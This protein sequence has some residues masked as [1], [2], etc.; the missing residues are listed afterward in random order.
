ME[1]AKGIKLDNKT[2]NKIIKEMKDGQRN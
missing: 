2:L 1:I